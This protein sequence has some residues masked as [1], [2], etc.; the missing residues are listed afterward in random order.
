MLSLLSKQSRDTN[1]EL[2]LG[3][4]AD[5]HKT[6]SAAVQVL[7]VAGLPVRIA[8]GLPLF[9]E[10]VHVAPE[11]W[12]QVFDAGAWHTFDPAS[13][14]KGLPDD[15]L[16]V[17]FGEGTLVGVEGGRSVTAGWSVR[18]NEEAALTAALERGR[19]LSRQFL[20]FSLFNL[21]LET[22]QVYQVLLLI[23]LGAFLLVVLRN[24]VGIKTFGTFMP[25]LIALAFRETQ[26]FWGIVLFVILVGLGLGIR[27]YLE[28]LK[29]LLVP[30]LGALLIIVVLLMALV[31]ILSHKMGLERGLSV[32]L[33]PMV[34]I[35][36]TIERMS[37]VWEERGALEALH[38]GFGS[39]L[40]ASLSYL[41]MFN[42]WSEHL[43]FVF[44]ELLL[45]FLSITLLLGRYSG[46]RILELGRFKV[47]A[48][49]QD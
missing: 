35:A 44:P 12:L 25:V 16:L 17:G 46:Y 49:G 11:P 24:I 43:V 39:L 42:L 13:G 38:Q 3:T 29:L 7:S 32:A 22:Q 37:V 36:M 2:L 40:V 23:P 21:P 28:H 4:A 48:K 1:A 9:Q 15:V 8:W 10:R 14:D 26:L 45:V 5:A 27:F 34:I 30:R 6:I 19:L 31:S 33:F 20:D 47:L 18:R 41:L